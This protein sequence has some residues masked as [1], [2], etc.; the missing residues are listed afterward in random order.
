MKVETFRGHKFVSF[1]LIKLLIKARNVSILLKGWARRLRGV[2]D[3]EQKAALAT[4]RYAQTKRIISGAYIRRN[5]QISEMR[6]KKK[7]PGSTAAKNQER[8]NNNLVHD[9]NFYET[10]EIACFLS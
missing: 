4:R 7:V 5:L 1:R 9:M 6:S 3:R 2:S 8:K 10:C